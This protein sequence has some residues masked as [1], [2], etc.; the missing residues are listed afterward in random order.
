[1]YNNFGQMKTPK[2]NVYLSGQNE[3]NGPLD[4]APRPNV[5][6]RYAE[7]FS[8]STPTRGKMLGGRFSRENV[9][10]DAASVFK[11]ET[12]Q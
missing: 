9:S 2:H 11:W 6:T 12:I 8:M 10:S 5:N 7:V 1:M 4:G 3:R